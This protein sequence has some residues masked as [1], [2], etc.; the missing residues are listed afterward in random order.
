M[1]FSVVEKK[2]ISVEETHITAVVSVML[3]YENKLRLAPDRAR[4][5]YS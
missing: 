2:N 3:K 5:A 4:T 1:Y